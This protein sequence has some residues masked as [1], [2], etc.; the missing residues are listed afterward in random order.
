VA[1]PEAETE[2]VLVTV[3]PQEEPRVEE[4]HWW[5]YMITK[6]NLAYTHDTRGNT[7]NLNLGGDARLRDYKCD[8][9]VDTIYDA[10]GSYGCYNSPNR[11]CDLANRILGQKK[12]ALN[13]EET[14]QRWADNGG[15]DVLEDYLEDDTNE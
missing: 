3:A 7:C 4:V 11:R 12:D 10:Q 15:E 8:G 14:H 9:T 5:G 6:G 13:V 1:V 2:L